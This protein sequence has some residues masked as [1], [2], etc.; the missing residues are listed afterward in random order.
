MKDV[1]DGGAGG[2]GG[3]RVWEV[4]VPSEQFFCNSEDVQKS[5]FKIIEERKEYIPFI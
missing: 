2:E 3:G 1:S 4:S 5:L